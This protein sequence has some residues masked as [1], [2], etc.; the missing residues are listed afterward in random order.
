MTEF[1]QFNAI[2]LR[3]L[4]NYSGTS[5]DKITWIGTGWFK[6]FR[7]DDSNGKYPESCAN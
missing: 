5:A 1:L 7:K 3:T 6:L 4:E 2:P